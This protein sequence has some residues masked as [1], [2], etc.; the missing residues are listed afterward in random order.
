MSQRAFVT[1]FCGNY[2]GSTRQRVVKLTKGPLS[3]WVT[4]EEDGKQRFSLTYEGEQAV[5]P[6]REGKE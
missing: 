6:F 1:A 5:A 2:N 3:E 4:R